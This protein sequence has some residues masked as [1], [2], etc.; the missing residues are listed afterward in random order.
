[1]TEEVP[2]KQAAQPKFAVHAQTFSARQLISG[3]TDLSLPQRSKPAILSLVPRFRHSPLSG[4]MFRSAPIWVLA[5]F[6]AIVH[7]QGP[8]L[9][10][11]QFSHDDRADGHTVLLKAPAFEHTH[12]ER[13]HSALDFSHEDHH[14][15][16]FGSWDVVPDCLLKAA[17]VIFSVALIAA[18]GF[19]LLSAIPAAAVARLYDRVR[20]PPWPPYIARP[21]RAP[22]R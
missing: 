8:W 7:G 20:A 19:L 1:M 16:A 18:I 3:Q 17:I 12:V 15:S 2:L 11:H 9:H 5:L 10:T 13:V 6:L 4:S 21:T 22:P 14:G